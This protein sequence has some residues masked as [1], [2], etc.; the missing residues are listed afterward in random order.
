MFSIENMSKIGYKIII[1]CHSIEKGLSHFIIRPFGKNKI[2]Y[3]INLL[4][5]SLKYPNYENKFFFIN[6][7]NIL[8]EYKKIYEKRNWIE[9]NEY[10]KTIKFLKNFENIKK[11]NVGAYI[12]KKDD[13][14]K[15]YTFNFENFV[16]SRHSFRSFQI[17]KLSY[18]DIKKV[19]EISKYAPSACNRQNIKIHYYSS[20]KLRQ[21]IIDFCLGTRNNFVSGINIFII[22]Y[23]LNGLNGKGGRN[24]GYFNAGLFTMNLINTF[25]SKGIG[26]YLIQLENDIEKEEKLKKLNHIPSNERIANILLAGYYD[27]KSIFPLSPRKEVKYYLKIH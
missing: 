17:K 23:D 10:K 7:I 21:N 20:K 13:L 26:T 18:K 1:Y 11:I 27:E 15:N 8:R 6:G 9:K 12:L 4:K 22:T 5:L 2:L 24:Q 3:I 25:H 14:N 19:I 16:K